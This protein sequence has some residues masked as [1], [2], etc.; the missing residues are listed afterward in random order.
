MVSHSTLPFGPE[1][2]AE[3][4][5]AVSQ[6]NSQ[7]NHFEFAADALRTA[8]ASIFELW[9]SERESLCWPLSGALLKPP[10]VAD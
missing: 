5:M 2:K 1:L 4:L 6:S 9:F 3:G 8:R 7:S 10:V